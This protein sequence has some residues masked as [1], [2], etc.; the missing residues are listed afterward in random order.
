MV[1]AFPTCLNAGLVGVDDLSFAPG[2]FR[3]WGFIV[4]SVCLPRVGIYRLLLVSSACGKT[5]GRSQCLVCPR[6]GS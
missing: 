6:E 4:C 5:R 3:V 1:C 2:V